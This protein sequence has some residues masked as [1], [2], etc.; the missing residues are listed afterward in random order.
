YWGLKAAREAMAALDEGS[1][2][3]DDAQK[4]VE[5]DLA[6]GKGNFTVTDKLRLKTARADLETRILEARKI[7]EVAKGGLRGLLGPNATPDFDIDDED[8]APKEVTPRPVIFYEDLARSSR[9]EVRA[10]NYAVKAKRA[11]ADLERRKEYPD[12]VLIATGALARAQDVQDP[13]N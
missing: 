4:K 2:Y 6:D 5:K 12:L 1:G 8:L 3:L 10:L 13:Q 11:L 9:P 7:A